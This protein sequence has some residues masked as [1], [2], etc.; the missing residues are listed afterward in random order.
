NNFEGT[1][2][3]GKVCS[4][5][6]FDHQFVAYGF[7]NTSSKIM[8]RILSLDENDVIDKAFFK[9][10]IEYALEHRKTLGW[11]A[12]RLVFSEADFLPGL[13][14]DKYGD[15]LS[16]QFMSLGMDMIKQDIVDIL[17]EL[18]GCKG[19]YERSDM[20]VREKEGLEQKKGFLYGS[21]N[22][23]V[24]IVEDG[25]HMIVDMENG[26]KT[27][28]F[29]D[30]KLNRDILR[31]YAKDKYVLDAFSNVGGFALHACKY[32]ASHVDACDISQRACDEI[33]NNAKLNGYHQLEAKCVDVFDF[34][35]DNANANKYDLI[36]LDPPAFSKSKES[37]KKA[38]RGYKDINMQAMKIIK[39]G[40]YLLTFSCSQHMTPDLFMQM[41]S[42]AA[43]DAKRTVQ[44][45]DFRIQSPDH[46]ALLQAGEQLYLK[47]LILR[48][49]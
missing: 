8:V 11:E 36:V 25:I 24:E 32:G 45:L 33:L 10:R 39:S 20:P 18:T 27:G 3:N 14:V 16:V 42:E 19:I 43:N 5:Y 28:Y 48:V 40:G 22:P 34:L 23:R 15:Y 49:K 1:I 31:L 37:L 9:T 29:L 6:T 41:V 44:F 47:C 7:L 35:H 4:V 17:V 2:E 38:Y 12:T 26:Q 21:F 13:V 30:Q 46:T